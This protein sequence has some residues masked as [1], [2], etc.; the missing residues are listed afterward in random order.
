M[1]TALVS[2][3]QLCCTP[4]CETLCAADHGARP[5]PE[6]SQECL[7]IIIVRPGAGPFGRQD[8][9]RIRNQIPQEPQ[10]DDP[11]PRFGNIESKL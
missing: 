1:F 2:S 11:C 6:E 8:G 7:P 10:A 9:P 3:T 5:T 4:R